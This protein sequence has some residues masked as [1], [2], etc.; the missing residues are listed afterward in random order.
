MKHLL[1]GAIALLALLPASAQVTEG[2]ITYTRTLK[3][4]MELPPE[5]AA[6]TAGMPKERKDNYELLFAKNKS[7]FHPVDEPEDMTMDNGNGVVIRMMPPGGEMV[8]YTD[9]DNKKKIEQKELGTKQYVVE[10]TLPKLNW[11]LTGETKTILGHT[12]KKATAEREVKHMNM[13]DDNGKVTH[14]MVTDTVPV[15]AWYADDITMFS[16]P[17]Y[18]GSLPGMILELSIDDGRMTYLA[19]K[20]DPKY[21]KKTLAL[22][23]DGKKISAADYKKEQDAFF[24]KMQEN[25]GGRMI[26]KGD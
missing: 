10:D 7:L 5:F 8:V 6:Q 12:C 16:G 21:D 22:P 13:N 1:A 20:I 4:K 18:A 15:E 17:E 3:L 26:I 23:K 2:T 25:G 11:K 14:E 24:K 19:T 9:L